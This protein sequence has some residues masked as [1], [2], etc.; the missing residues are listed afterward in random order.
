MSTEDDFPKAS[1][2]THLIIFDKPVPEGGGIQN[3]AYWLAQSL[4]NQ[5]LRVVIAGQKKYLRHPAYQGSGIEFIETEKPFRTKHTSDIRLIAL[6][7][8]IKRKL[9]GKV[10]AYSLILNHK[11]Q[12]SMPT[13]GIKT[14]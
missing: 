4:K 1:E 2:Y 14:T 9:P 10:I 6:A 5:G 13:C 12:N 8:R 11:A 3:M 7:L